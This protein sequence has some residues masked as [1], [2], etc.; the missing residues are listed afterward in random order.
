MA[1]SGQ[2]E[3]MELDTECMSLSAPLEKGTKLEELVKGIRTRK[4]LKVGILELSLPRLLTVLV[5]SPTSPLSTTTTT[6]C[7]SCLDTEVL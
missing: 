5:R 3:P 6:S 2:F 4:G 1:V 7:N